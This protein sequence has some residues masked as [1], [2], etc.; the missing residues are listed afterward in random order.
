M[1]KE[2]ERI[3][4]AFVSSML[5]RDRTFGAPGSSTN[6]E[7]TLARSVI[8]GAAARAD[9]HYGGTYDSGTDVDACD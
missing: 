4:A 2:P 3:V 5:K 8:G 9:V 1:T 7:A 6:D